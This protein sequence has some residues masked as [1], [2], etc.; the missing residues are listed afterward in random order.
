MNKIVKVG[1]NEVYE[2][3]AVDFLANI[4]SVDRIDP[5]VVRNAV[6]LTDGNKVLG[7][8]SYEKF[9]AYGL[10]RYFIFKS[11]INNTDILSLVETLIEQALKDGIDNLFSVVNKKEIEEFFSDL[12]FG[13]VDKSTFII[14]GKNFLDSK[15]KDAEIMLKW[16]V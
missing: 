7:I 15:Y 6:I 1:N 13:K 4:P 12:G 14:D 5:E 2:E 9:N 16:L 3:M 11:M 10:I 8:L